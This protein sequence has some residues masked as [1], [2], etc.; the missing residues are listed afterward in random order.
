MLL[1]LPPPRHLLTNSANFPYCRIAQIYT[2]Q[3]TQ[4]HHTGHLFPHLHLNPKLPQ[5]SNPP[6]QRFCDSAIPQI[7]DSANQQIRK[8]ANHRFSKSATQRLNK[9]IIY[10][11]LFCTLQ[12]HYGA[13]TF[14]NKRIESRSIPL[15][16]EKRGRVENL[17]PVNSRFQG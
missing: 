9:I 13:D 10:I 7:S 4:S 6:T 16:I 12:A 15:Y 3:V 11:D 14:C 17:M 5:I 8:S 2:T 1:K